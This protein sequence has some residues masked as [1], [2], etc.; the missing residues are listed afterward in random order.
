MHRGALRLHHIADILTQASPKGKFLV[1]REQV[2]LMDVTLQSKGPSRSSKGPSRSR[3]LSYALPPVWH[4]K[5]RNWVGELLGLRDLIDNRKL[6]ILTSYGKWYLAYSHSRMCLILTFGNWYLPYY[7]LYPSILPISWAYWD[8]HPSGQLGC[9]CDP[10]SIYT[11]VCIQP[12][13]WACWDCHPS[14]QLGCVGEENL[15]VCVILTSGKWYPSQL[16]GCRCSTTWFLRIKVGRLA[17]NRICV[18]L[19]SYSKWYP[20]YSH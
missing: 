17:D 14:G 6:V 19:T 7:K 8:F 5:K 16:I 15:D 9:V 18:I 4:P 10:T 13:S 1:F 3:T 2:G 11:P 12:I 20:T